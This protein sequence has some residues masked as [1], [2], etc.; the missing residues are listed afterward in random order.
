MPRK[1]YDVVKINPD[2]FFGD[3]PGAEV[4]AE[5]KS[6]SK[7]KAG[8]SRRLMLLAVFG[9]VSL[10]VICV[11]ALV[12][13]QFFGADDPTPTAIV[14]TPPILTYATLGVVP[15]TATI[16]PL[17]G[18]TPD[19]PR[20]ATYVAA[21]FHPAALNPGDGYV[22]RMGTTMLQPGCDTSNI[23]LDSSGSRYYLQL[24]ASIIININPT[25]QMVEVRGF[26]TRRDTCAY[27]VLQVQSFILINELATPSSITDTGT[28]SAD[29]W[30]NP[31]LPTSSAT[32]PASVPLAARTIPDLTPTATITP[33]PTYT[34]YPTITPLPPQQQPT[35]LPT[36]T[37]TPRLTTLYGQIK[38]AVGCAQTNFSVD[39]SGKAYFIILDG[40]TLPPGDPTLYDGLITGRLVDACNGQA[41]LAQTITW[42]VR[43]TPT[44]T[45]T[46]TPTP[47]PTG[48][49]TP[50]A[51]STATIT[52]VL[53][54]PETE[55]PTMTPN[56]QTTIQEGAQTE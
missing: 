49:D 51:T 52:P 12:S 46:G 16:A 31:V 18:E 14:V 36:A 48:T 1:E 3:V 26:L 24:P 22:V 7:N 54:P 47:T 45:P 11:G 28:I 35:R 21:L 34:P 15:P 2:E 20:T 40:A 30:Q 27:E 39:V 37:P 25:L 19:L 55:T 29:L 42:Y 53:T 56:G 32:V 41:V 44:P 5:P 33:Y 4:A 23:A 43:S 38:T 9:V 50:T 17:G 13:V 8:R 6:S 10:G